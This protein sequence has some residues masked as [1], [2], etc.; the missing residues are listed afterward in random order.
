[1]KVNVSFKGIGSKSYPFQASMKFQHF[2]SPRKYLNIGVKRLKGKQRS[3]S[4]N[5]NRRNENH[6]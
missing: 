2:L 6:E 3:L 1:M 5:L 4:T